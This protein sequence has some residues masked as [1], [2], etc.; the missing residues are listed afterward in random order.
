[1][2]PGLGD[3]GSTFGGDN[4]ELRSEREARAV[5]RERVTRQKKAVYAKALLVGRNWYIHEGNK[6]KD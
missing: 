5:E 6:L 2:V 1:M 4:T 3:Q